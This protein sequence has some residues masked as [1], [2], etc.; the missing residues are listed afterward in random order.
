[1]LYEIN[2]G[3]KYQKLVDNA[4]SFVINHLHLPENTWVD[5]FITSNTEGSCGG[6]VD[7]ES[8]GL[9]HY[10]HVDINNRLCRDELVRTLFHE[11]KHVE[12]ISNGKLDQLIWKGKDYS[13]IEY[14]DRPWEKEA[15]EFESRTFSIYRNQL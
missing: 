11:M 3:K 5:I 7:M 9:Y 14:N 8:D 12:Q 15:Y 1:M 10:F 2:S 13:N 6:C 4:M